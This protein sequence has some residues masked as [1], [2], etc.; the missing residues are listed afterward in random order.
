M[1]TLL[2]ELM[3][4][5]QETG[6]YAQ[7]PHAPHDWSPQTA[8]HMAQT[9]GVS[10]TDEHWEVVQ[11]L[12]EYFARHDLRE[13]NMRELHDA[14]EER[15]HARGGMKH[16][17]LLFPGGPVAQGCRVAGLPV[18]FLAVDRGFGSVM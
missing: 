10:L 4:K 11:A 1:T 12:Q 2:R 14:L 13:P 3:E 5:A 9:E 7:F 18:P 17:Y 8:L 15:F 6:G 16:L